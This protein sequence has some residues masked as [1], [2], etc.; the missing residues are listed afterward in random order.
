[1]ENM[2]EIS[3]LIKDLEF[4]QDEIVRI[5]EK[6][7]SKIN[8]YLGETKENNFQV[9]TDLATRDHDGVVITIEFDDYT[10]YY[11]NCSL[12]YNFKLNNYENDVRRFIDLSDIVSNALLTLEYEVKKQ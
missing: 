11:N 4:H 5:R 7:N 2:I 1:M 8:K 10:F 12:T 3:N 9:K 6:I